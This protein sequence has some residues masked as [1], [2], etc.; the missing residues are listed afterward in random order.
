M[1]RGWRIGAAPAFVPN[2]QV[3]TDGTN[4][5]AYYDLRSDTHVASPSSLST[6]PVASSALFVGDY[7]ALLAVG[8]R[9]VPVF[10]QTTGDL[11]NRTH[12]YV[13]FGGN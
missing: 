2:V 10:V 1:R 6:A 5:V 9:F 12:V 13:A 3:R 11:G 8:G 7:R 4:G